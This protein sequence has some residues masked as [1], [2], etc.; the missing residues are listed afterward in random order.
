VRLFVAF[1]IPIEL[2]REIVRRNLALREHLPRA[3]WLEAESMHLTLVF[4]GE[5]GEAR[6]SALME[7]GAGVLAGETPVQ[8][9]LGDTG[10][11]PPGRPAR[12]VWLAVEADR[13]LAPLQRRL[14]A[15]CGT[16]AEVQPDAKPYH[17]HLTVARCEPP[18][19]LTACTRLAAGYADGLGESFEVRDAVLFRSHLGGGPARHEALGRWPLEAR[20]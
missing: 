19:P 14:A 18:W 4:L 1:E 20:G 13:D 2:R 17:P 9:R 7:A 12:V 5:V 6:L 16:A 15:A 10:S 11:F 3:R 8:L